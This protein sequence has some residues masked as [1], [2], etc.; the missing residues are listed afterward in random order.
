MSHV[1][2]FI[3]GIMHLGDMIMSSS[4]IPVLK[5]AYPDSEIVYLATANLAYVASFFEG[6]DH[7][8]PYTYQSK[9]GYMD[10]YRM[11][12]ML[13]NYNFDIGISLDPRK[14]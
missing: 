10:V 2:I 12:K 1:K 14:E 5:K 11:G 7:V 3:D 8:I 4:V 13:R 6:I 9:G